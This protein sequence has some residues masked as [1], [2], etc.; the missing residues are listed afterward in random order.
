L[1][2]DIDNLIQADSD[3]QKLGMRVTYMKTMIY[4]LESVLGDIRSRGFTIK[5]AIEW[6]KFRAGN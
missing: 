1:K 6:Q 5:S 2:A 4:F 3:Y